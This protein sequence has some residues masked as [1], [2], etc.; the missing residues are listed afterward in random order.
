MAT[1]E[2]LGRGLR[3]REGGK[4][5]RERGIEGRGRREWEKIF[6]TV[7]LFFLDID[8]SVFLNCFLLCNAS[9]W[10]VMLLNDYRCCLNMSFSFKFCL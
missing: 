7:N 5:G 6:S 3:E 10:L 9:K 2:R 8:V 1:E 4:D